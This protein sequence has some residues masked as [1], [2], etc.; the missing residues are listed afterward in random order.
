MPHTRAVLILDVS[1]YLA[2]LEEFLEPFAK[3]YPWLSDPTSINKNWDWKNHT[4]SRDV[5]QKDMLIDWI[6]CQELTE[7]FYLHIQGHLQVDTYD[8]IY[9]RLVSTH[10]LRR[11]TGHY[12]TVPRIYGDSPSYLVYRQAGSLYIEYQYDRIERYR[13]YKY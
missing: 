1:N 5:T 2:I 8:S 10:D 9:S 4:T 13:P 3:S 6:I 12:L 7:M 11:C